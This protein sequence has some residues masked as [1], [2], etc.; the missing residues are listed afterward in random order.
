MGTI[1]QINKGINKPIVFKGFQGQYI[2]WLAG[3]LVC[4]LILFAVLFIAGLPMLVVL[5]LIL[6]LGL[7]LFSAT[8]YL[9]RRFGATGLEKHMASRSV[10]VY[11]KFKS[12]RIFTGLT[13]GVAC[14]K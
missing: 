13:K 1:Y 8:S 5:A 14:L 11:L 4:L 12:R 3:G 9:S 10:P 6:F 2:S 7:G